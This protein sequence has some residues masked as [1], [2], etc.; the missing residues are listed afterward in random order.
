[1]AFK[2]FGILLSC[3]GNGVVRV[4]KIKEIIDEMVKMGYNYLELCLDD[5]YK[6]DDEPYFGYLRGGYTAEEL[7]E[8]DDYAFSRGVELVPCVQTLA[9]MNNLLKNPHYGDIVD[10]GDCFLIDEPKTYELIEKM[11]K[12]IRECFRTDT[13]NIAMDEA[14]SVGLGRYLDL[15]G[16]ENRTELILRHLK[17]VLEIAKK[18]GFK[19]H[20]WSDM[21]FRLENQGGYYEPDTRFSQ[22]VLD[23]VPEDVGLCYWDYGEHEIKEE[24]FDGMFRAHEEFNREIW[25]AGGAWCWLGYAPQNR[26]SLHVM[27]PA[28][29]QAQAH[30][31]ENVVITLW[32]DDGNDCP[33]LSVLPSL[34]AISEYAK[35][36]YDEKKI[37]TGFKTL[38]G[39]DFYDF[40][41]LD[42]PN[43]TSENPDT[44][45][46]LNVAKVLLFNDCF[47]GHKD[48][49]LSALEPIPF[50]EYARILQETGTR[51]GK[52]KPLFE[53]LS[54]LCSA[55]DVK[56][57]LGVRT[58]E[59]YQKGDKEGLRALI[60]DYEEAAVRVDKF[61]RSFRVLWMEDY[62][63]Y[64]W[65]VQQIRLGG[66]YT[67]ILDCKERLEEYLAGQVKSIPELEETILPF[68]EPHDFRMR[69]YR[70]MSTVNNI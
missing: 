7:K 67:R 9:H 34:Y 28:I 42:I 17:K 37:A 51:M 19:S 18:Y 2:R 11:F 64:G 10:T 52:F 23:K 66:L 56:A 20:M 4:E 38:F 63:P 8:M 29:R 39:V 16:Y 12:K 6:L 26:W 55:L 5:V 41:Q 1:M 25:F 13:V 14:H 15:H 43:K 57:Y 32:G 50:G 46:W 35:G 65:E 33:Y 44:C 59:A 45:D 36:N 69:C 27:E 53:N 22:E 61:R 21:F 62:K 58:R 31:V 54:L 49:A 30:G 47:L 40:M 60:A 68:N 48:H 3:S 24:I 70:M